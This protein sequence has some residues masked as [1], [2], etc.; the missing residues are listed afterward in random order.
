[1]SETKLIILKVEAPN[2]GLSK[3]LKHIDDAIDLMK[4]REGAFVVQYDIDE[5]AFIQAVKKTKKDMLSRVL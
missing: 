2:A 4:A 1:M 3:A 5:K